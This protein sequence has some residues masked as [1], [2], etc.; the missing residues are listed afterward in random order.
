MVKEIELFHD[1]SISQAIVKGLL[2][3]NRRGSN[4]IVKMIKSGHV[5]ND[6]LK[7]FQAELKKRGLKAS[8]IDTYLSEARAGIKD[9]LDRLPLSAGQ[10]YELVKCLNVIKP[11]KKAPT[12]K[13]VK[14]NQYIKIDDLKAVLE[15]YQTDKNIKTVFILKLL[16][17][18]GLRISEALNIKLSDVKKSGSMYQVTVQGKGNK[19]RSIRIEPE[20]YK[21][22]KKTFK[23]KQY[24][25]ESSSGLMLN[26]VNVYKQVNRFFRKA[27]YSLS[28]HSLRH[29]FATCAI[30]SGIPINE[31]A[32]YLG[33]SSIQTTASMYAHNVISNEKLKT[34]LV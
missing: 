10:R 4:L 27:G 1:D 26:R 9:Q 32:D 30:L 25:F 33:H 14:D 18:T 22:V 28:P 21:A 5:K 16:F 3:D 15:N 24:L 19:D 20:L 8:S 31:I 7:E 12:E 2:R 23:G 11:R 29:S 34:L 6:Y 13:A 17:H